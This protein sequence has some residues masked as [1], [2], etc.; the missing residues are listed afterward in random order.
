MGHQRRRGFVP[1][2]TAKEP[3]L[4]P[5]GKEGVAH[6]FFLEVKWQTPPMLTW[7]N[8]FV[9]LEPIFRKVDVVM[10]FRKVK[11]RFL[12]RAP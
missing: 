5:T 1:S 2:Y 8:Q 11:C 4:A 3:S 9:V 10:W 12:K 6:C 7:A